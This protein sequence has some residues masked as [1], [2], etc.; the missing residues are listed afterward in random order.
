MNKILAAA[1]RLRNEIELGGGY[2]SDHL[3]VT[4]RGIHV[5]TQPA[6]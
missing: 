1:S 4:E 2:W 6:A 5:N 3:R